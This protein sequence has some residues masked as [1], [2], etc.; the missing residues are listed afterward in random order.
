MK[1]LAVLFLLAIAGLALA[2]TAATPAAQPA[3]TTI[4]LTVTTADLACVGRVTKQDP[5]AWLQANIDQLVAQ[6]TS[7]ERVSQL[8]TLGLSDLKAA[9]LTQSE[10]DTVVALRRASAT[11]AASAAPS[12]ASPTAAPTP[13]Q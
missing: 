2:Q 13:G 6:C 8:R 9:G 10:I 7:A 1:A 12:S 3:T 11:A 5:A 4:T